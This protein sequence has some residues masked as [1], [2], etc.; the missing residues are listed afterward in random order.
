MINIRREHTERI[1]DF[2][3]ELT[4]EILF[5]PHKLPNSMDENEIRSYSVLCSIF[6][7]TI[8]E[9]FDQAVS[10]SFSEARGVIICALS[11]I[12]LKR[13]EWSYEDDLHALKLSEFIHLC[14]RDEVLNEKTVSQSHSRVPTEFDLDE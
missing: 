13:G 5:G 6:S 2:A 4:Q 11:Q 3:A 8:K 1:G 14:V 12:S 7:N 10:L 9:C